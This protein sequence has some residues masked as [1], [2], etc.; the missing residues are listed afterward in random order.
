M[1]TLARWFIGI[2]LVAFGI[3]QL[4]YR[5][6]VTRLVPKLPGW[7]P[8]HSLW[9]CVL[10]IVLIVAGAAIAWGKKARWAGIL[11]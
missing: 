6:F 7:I 5:E 4:V 9:A 10:G 8:W 1:A 2:A 3:Q 11:L